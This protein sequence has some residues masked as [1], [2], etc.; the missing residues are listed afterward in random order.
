[1]LLL[2]GFAK[3]SEGGNIFDSNSWWKCY[4]PVIL[5]AVAVTTM[6]SH[7][8]KVAE[9]LTEWEN[10]ETTVDHGNSL[11]VKR[12]LFEAFDAYIILF[13]LAIYEGDIK[14]LRAELVGAF[15]IDTFRR[16]FTES[17]LPYINRKF[18]A[19]KK[20]PAGA[21]KKNDVRKEHPSVDTLTSEADLDEYDQ[22]GKKMTYLFQVATRMFNVYISF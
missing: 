3:L 4:L 8:S 15:N 18:A 11:I 14:L 22:F 13:Y 10:H 21:S 9:Q 16:L 20:D 17:I 6:N 19:N 2:S 1:M 5:R 12:F 7:Y